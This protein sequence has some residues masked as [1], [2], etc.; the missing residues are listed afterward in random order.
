MN[1]KLIWILVSS[2]A[3]VSSCKKYLDDAYKNP[4][5][6]TSAPPEQVLQACISG[7]HRGLAFD[8]RAIAHATQNWALSGASGLTWQCER[9]GYTPNSDFAGDIWRMHYWS[10]GYNIIDIIDSS[11]LAGKWDY[12]GAAYALNSWSWVTTAD[13][14]GE[15]PVT[16]AF[17]RGR[18]RF[19]YDN[20]PVAYNLAL[21][22]A[23]SAIKY[24]NLALGMTNSTLAVGDAFFYQGNISRWIKFTNGMKARIY[25][26]SSNKGSAYK[27]DSVIRYANLAMS[28]TADDAFVR[29]NLNFPDVT[30]RNFFGPSR[31]N[32][33]LMRIGQFAANTMNGTL[34]GGVIDPRARYM[35]RPSPDNILRGIYP[36]NQ[37]DIGTGTQRTTS[38][39]GVV[40]QTAAPA[41]GIDTGARTFFRNDSPFPIMTYSEMQFLAAEANFIKGDNASAKVAYVNAINGHFDMLNTHFLG[42]YQNAWPTTG[43]FTNVPIPA[44]D[45][46]AYITNTNIVPAGNVPLRSIM[47]QKYIAQ[48]S[49]GIVENWVDM[50]RYSYDTTN[51]YNTF[52]HL[53][54]TLIHPDNGGKLMER[55]RPRYNSEY[56]WNVDA[57]TSVGGFNINYHTKKCWFSL[58]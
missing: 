11:K 57:L 33:G 19:D 45:R 25:H 6:Q 18:L 54:L 12:V 27:P 16:Q 44:A 24:L 37:A 46:T 15:L 52:V 7:M 32:L 53:P 36:S 47:L 42:Y 22:Y 5:K 20:Q 30:A 58:P 2:I 9:H 17:E 4:N 50:R 1:K 23:D 8:A 40:G 28:S 14:H 21:Q 34:F 55:L 51:I 29:F 31:N 26:R 39:W 35:V 43:T 56:L 49:W 48:W 3:L 41:G 13:V 10:L 38:F